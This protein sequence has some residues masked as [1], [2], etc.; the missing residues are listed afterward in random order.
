MSQ[1]VNTAVVVGAGATGSAVAVLL[2]EAGDRVLLVTRSGSGPDHPRIER[3]AADA[4]DPVRLTALAAGAEVLINCAM[5]PYDR[6]PTEFPPLAASL[7]STAEA[8]GAG[9]VMLGNLYGYGPV[10]GPFTDDLPLA[11]S[12][13]KGEVRARMW[14][15]AL[16]SH[17]AGRARVTEVRASDFLGGGAYS[18]FTILVGDQVLAGRPA[19]YPGDLDVP[20]SWCYA[21]D[22]A[23]TLVAAA[24]HE[25]SWGRAW[26][27]PPTSDLPVRGLAA[28]LAARAGAP[29]PQLVLM[30]EAELAAAARA[31]SVTAEFPE[32]LY[33][34]NRPL[35]LDATATTEKLG[36]TATPLDEVLDSM[37]APAA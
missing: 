28:R 25:D 8:T 5:P 10:D 37:V 4:S 3:V 12:S 26:H 22:V 23:R 17:E 33:L 6:W 27:V 30:T 32:V 7:L 35:L 20:H 9:Y 29:A 2:A 14:R 18:P 16:A 21:G 19:A 31:D 36:V 11:P 34:L 1:H 15:D 24:R 13:V